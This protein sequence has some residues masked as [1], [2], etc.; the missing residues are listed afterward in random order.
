MPGTEKNLINASS[1]PPSPNSQVRQKFRQKYKRGHKAGQA[2]RQVRS[3][4]SVC[5]GI[6]RTWPDRS[7]DASCGKWANPEGR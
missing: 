4:G 5:L 2:K 1:C 3:M 7:A 6:A